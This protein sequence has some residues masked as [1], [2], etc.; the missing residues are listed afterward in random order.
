MTQLELDEAGI[1]LIDSFEGFSA[2]P[3]KDVRGIWTI[4]YGHVIKPG[5]KFTSL[6][7]EAAAHLMYLDAQTAWTGLNKAVQKFQL[8]QNSV[9]ALVS[10]IF[11]VGVGGFSSSPIPALLNEGNLQEA[12]VH[13]NLW[14]RAGSQVIPGLVTRRAKETALMLTPDSTT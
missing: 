9:D 7:R 11:N 3:Y 5:E 10:F 14:V 4:G 6:T 8:S 12:A 2:T 13:M 1:T